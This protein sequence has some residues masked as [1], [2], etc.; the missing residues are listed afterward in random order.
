MSN[1]KFLIMVFFINRC[2]AQGLV[3]DK[4]E[5]IV[6]EF[7][8]EHSKAWTKLPQPNPKELY[9]VLDSIQQKFCTNKLRKEAKEWFDEGHDLI[10]NDWGVDDESIST[11]EVLK[12]STT[13]N[14]YVVSYIVKSYPVSPTKPVSKRVVLYVEV[15]LIDDLCKI[16]SVK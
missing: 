2:T 3:E 7:Y 1:I 6:K 10:T 13:E 8:I 16:N 14:R 15:L 12:D 5:S 4:C 11:I 9:F